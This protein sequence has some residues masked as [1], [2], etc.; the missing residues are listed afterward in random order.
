M[1]ATVSKLVEDW[2]VGE[3]LEKKDAIGPF[4][5]LANIYFSDAHFLFALNEIII[6][7]GHWFSSINQGGNGHIEGQFVWIYFKYDLKT[8]INCRIV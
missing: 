1:A 3:Q 6:Y 7:V 8:V 2:K 5:T 4:Y